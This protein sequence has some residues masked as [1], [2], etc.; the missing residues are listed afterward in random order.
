M[1][2]VMH[3]ILLNIKLKYL[4]IEFLTTHFRTTSRI[5]T[6]QIMQFKKKNEY[7]E[8]LKRRI[9]AATFFST[10]VNADILIASFSCTAKYENF[11][12]MTV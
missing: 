1:F 8:I 11:L 6:I 12:R 3:L 2:Q 5:D 7:T 4:I 10:C 9:S